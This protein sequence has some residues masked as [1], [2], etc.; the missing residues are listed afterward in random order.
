MKDIFVVGV[1][2]AIVFFVL[3]PLGGEGGDNGIVPSYEEGES[4]VVFSPR[5]GYEV[6]LF[7]VVDR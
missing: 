7:H 5:S 2:L 3:P 4:R 6:L 1:G